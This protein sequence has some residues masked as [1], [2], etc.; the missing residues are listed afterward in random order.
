[1]EQKQL[2]EVDESYF[3]DD[4][5]DD[6]S[7][8][9]LEE[10][11][12]EPV[13]AEKKTKADK[14]IKA[15][16]EVK[17]EKKE[18]NKK[19]E[20]SEKPKL[21]EKESAD[22]DRNVETKPVEELPS[23]PNENLVNPWADDKEPN[24][25]SSWKTFAGI[26]V[27]LLI[28]SVFTNGFNFSGDQDDTKVTSAAVLSLSEAEQKALDYVNDNLLQAPFTAEV[29]SSADAGDLYRVTLTV[30]G[31]AVDSYITKDGKLFFPQGFDTTA[32][33]EETNTPEETAEQVA[34][35][36]EEVS[37]AMGETPVEEVP[38]T[39]EETQMEET[40]EPTEEVIEPTETTEV[41]EPVVE[42]P[43]NSVVANVELSLDAKRWLFTP[44]TLTVNKGDKVSLTINPTDLS[45]TFA[46]PGLGVEQEVTG[47]TTLEFT[48][49]EAGSFDFTCS[50]CEDWRGM[51][52]VLTVE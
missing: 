16:S 50:S 1:M 28:F 3:G 15:N 9:D 13:K 19:L 10:V 47:L 23:K 8:A 32:V 30:A 44:D 5:I 41:E 17:A 14:T 27:V 24:K 45:F 46:I 20:A 22:P 43:T 26:L 49:E 4:F 42:E 6:D 11:K 35:V 48:A 12:I 29:E 34:E 33:M 39:T 40:T 31:Q 38:E 21:E 37:E 36:N 25:G 51:D 52:G 7:L 18:E 2:D